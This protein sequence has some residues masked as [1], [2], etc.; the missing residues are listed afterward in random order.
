MYRCKESTGKFFKII[1]VT[2]YVTE[3]SFLE[4]FLPVLKWI[5]LGKII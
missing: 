2:F 5:I 3:L 4:L 1:F